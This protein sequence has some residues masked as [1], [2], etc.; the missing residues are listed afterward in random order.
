[1]RPPLAGRGDAFD[2]PDD[3]AGGHDDPQIVSSER[4]ELLDERTLALEPAAAVQASQAALQGEAAPAHRY[5]LPPAAEPR[6]D[7]DRELEARIG[8]L[9]DVSGTGVGKTA[10]CQSKR[11][12]E[13]V[14][15]AEESARA[16][17]HDHASVLQGAQLLEP[18]LGPV[19]RPEHV[20]PPDGHVT[21]TK[22][23]VGLLRRDDERVESLCS[24]RVEQLTVGLGDGA[25]DDCEALHEHSLLVGAWWSRYV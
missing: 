5:V 15:C 25:C 2:G 12:D 8:I 14:V 16:I 11:R 20:E 7:D 4:D 9:A 13:L 24:C 21:C 6:L 3:L 19:E 23:P 18:G 1:M 10:S 17:E 22:A